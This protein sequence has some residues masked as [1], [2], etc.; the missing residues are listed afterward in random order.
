M[1]RDGWFDGRGLDLINSTRE[2]LKDKWASFQKDGRISKDECVRLRQ[3]IYRALRE[4]EADLDD[5]IHQ[6]LTPILVM[7]EMLVELEMVRASEEEQ[8][9]REPPA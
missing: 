1:A 8:E 6:R 5:G 2:A 3:E 9:E 7:Y 4:I